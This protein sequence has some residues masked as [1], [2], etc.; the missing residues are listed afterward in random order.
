[1][2]NFYGDHVCWVVG[3]LDILLSIAG[4]KLYKDN[5]DKFVEDISTQ[6]CQSHSI[7][8]FDYLGSSTFNSSWY[9]LLCSADYLV[10]VFAVARFI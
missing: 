1:M 9:R 3:Y 5:Q 7:Y 4:N 6:V 2:A 8:W 10:R